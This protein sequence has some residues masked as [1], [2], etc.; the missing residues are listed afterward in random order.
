[1]KASLDQILA[2]LL[3]GRGRTH[4][5]YPTVINSLVKIPAPEVGTMAVTV[6]DGANVLMYNPQLIE[7]LDFEQIVLIITH[8]VMHLVLNHIPRMMRLYAQSP[9]SRR[10][11]LQ[12]VSNIAAD[13][14]V[15]SL[16]VQTR[17]C[18]AADFKAEGPGKLPG[19]LPTDVDLPMGKSYEWYVSKL[20]EQAH[21]LP[22]LGS[23][24]GQTQD[25][26]DHIIIVPPQGPGEESQESENSE[27]SGPITLTPDQLAELLEEYHSKGAPL[28]Q[29]ADLNEALKDMT[30]LEIEATADRTER[31]IKKSVRNA[32]AATKGRGNLA[33]TVEEA[34][35]ELLKPPTL[36]WNQ[37]LKRLI[38]NA[39]KT[40]TVRSMARPKRRMLDSGGRASPYPGTK[41]NPKFD[42]LF[43]VDTSGSMSQDDMMLCLSEIQ[44]VQKTSES[45]NIT[46]IEADTRIQKEY[47]LKPGGTL[48]TFVKGRGGT[49]F[50]EVFSR[51]KELKPDILIYGTDGECPLPRPDNRVPCPVLWVLTPGGS[52]PGS[53]WGS[54]RKDESCQYGRVVRINT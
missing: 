32:K 7:D 29:H 22:Q 53:S 13:Y 5:F 37:L 54:R 21:N 25:N 15:N 26:G 36:P 23:Q 48:D 27:E 6:K 51:A 14:A 41:T 33:G 43:A 50:N 4:T 10:K 45:M 49:D 20:I 24:G 19:I 46:V 31:R 3:T 1:M 38:T 17:E 40:T 11:L 42:V 18:T 35:G 12:K 2:Y 34:I 52:V 16:M 28:N 9:E 30:D 47:I 39:K 44:G 8:E